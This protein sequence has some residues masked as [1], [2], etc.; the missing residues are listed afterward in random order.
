MAQGERAHLWAVFK[1]RQ[2]D[3]D[4]MVAHKILSHDPEAYLAIAE[5]FNRDARVAEKWS[6]GTP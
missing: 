3:L 2:P 5:R 4:R 6:T 1:A